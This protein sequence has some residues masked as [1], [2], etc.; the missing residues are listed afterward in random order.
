MDAAIIYLIGPM[1]CGKTTVGK[2]LAK[3]LGWGFADADDFHPVEN[4]KKMEA[5]IPLT[6]EDRSPWLETLQEVMQKA[7]NSGENYV[8]ACSA[9]RESYR[10]ILGID[11]IRCISIYL[12]GTPE[13]LRKR[14]QQRHHPYMD[15]NLLTS[16]LEAFEE[17]QTGMT[18]E[19]SESPEKIVEAIMVHLHS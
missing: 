12:K 13:L 8:V 6:D 2:L 10:E 16:Q 15:N 19:I 7:S 18:V 11:Q 1:G 17:P 4:V 14:L 9:L 5:G 3:K